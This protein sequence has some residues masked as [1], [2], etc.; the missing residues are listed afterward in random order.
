LC[1]VQAPLRITVRGE[2]RPAV[3]RRIFAPADGVVERVLVSDGQSV[4]AGQPLI[5]LRSPDL[6]LRMTDILGQAD[7]LRNRKR[8]IRSERLQLGDDQALR[9]S[10]LI[11]EEQAID[12]QLGALKRQFELLESQQR[13]LTLLSPID[14]MVVDWDVQQSLALRPVRR[15]NVLL[16]IVD[17]Q[18]PWRLEFAAPDAEAGPIL[19]AQQVAGGPLELSF[20]AASAPEQPRQAVVSRIDDASHWSERERQLCVLIE[21]DF[22]RQGM[23][24]LR[25]GMS[26]VGKF[27]CG[28][29]AAGLVWF[30]ELYHEMRRRFF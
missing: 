27:D 12:L 3:Q 21:A 29:R 20:V 18:G 25:H 7:T 19:Q 30:H 16:T 11:S 1:L 6:E 10:E 23:E 2:A 15:G 22:D 17:P 5:E 28:R 4:V 14:G 26:V 13:D 8:T 24:G 9:Q